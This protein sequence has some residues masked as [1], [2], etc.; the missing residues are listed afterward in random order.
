MQKPVSWLVLVHQTCN[1]ATI[2]KPKQ[3]QTKLNLT[4]LPF[5]PFARKWTELIPQILGPAWFSLNCWYW[6]LYIRL[7][8]VVILGC[9]ALVAQRPIAIK[10]SGGRSVGPYIRTYMRPSVCPVHCGKT[11]DRIRMPF[12]II[13][14]TGPGMRQV[15]GFGDWSMGRGTFGSKFGARHCNQCG[16]HSVLVWQRRDVALL[17]NYFGQTCY[18]YAANTGHILLIPYHNK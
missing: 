17:P 5:I 10:L 2:Q 3:Q 6:A 4:Q 16:L 11:A 7:V 13:G 1:Q 9:V 8:T 15:V 14:Q 12:G 18:N